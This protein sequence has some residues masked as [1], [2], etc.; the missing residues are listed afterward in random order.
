MGIISDRVIALATEVNLLESEVIEL[1]SQIDLLNF[2]VVSEGEEYQAQIA[3]LTRIIKEKEERI[4]LLEAELAALKPAPMPSPVP[5]PLPVPMPSPPAP[6]PT[7]PPII[8]PSP[9]AAP[10][11]Q[12]TLLNKTY[13]PSGPG[14]LWPLSGEY[15]WTFEVNKEITL[16]LDSL[17]D[18]L[19]SAIQNKVIIQRA[20]GDL[21]TPTPTPDSVEPPP[22]IETHIRVVIDKKIAY[23]G[24]ISIKHH[25]R[26]AKT[27]GRL[28]L[29]NTLSQAK[30]VSPFPNYDFS[31]I[32]P[33]T[34]ADLSSWQWKSWRQYH[35]TTDPWTENFGFITRSF[36]GGVPIANEAAMFPPW[37]VYLALMGSSSEVG[38]KLYNLCADTWDASGNFAI[39]YFDRATGQPY[40]PETLP[41]SIP[42]LKA[43]N[44]PALFSRSG[45][46]LPVGDIAHNFGLVNFAALVT[47]E[48]FYIE[49]L[50]SWALLGPIVKPFNE[51]SLGVYISGQWRSTAWWLRD[52]FHLYIS[53]PNGSKRSSVRK[54]LV[55]AITYL[56]DRF[57]RPTSKHYHPTGILDTS[58]FGDG[59]SRWLKYSTPGPVSLSGNHHFLAHVVNEIRQSGIA[60]FDTLTEPLLRHLVKSAE[61]TWKYSPTKYMAPWLKHVLGSDWPETMKLTFARGP[62]PYSSFSDPLTLDITAWWRANVIAA[63]ELGLPWA[64]E[65]LWWVDREIKSTGRHQSV[66][67]RIKPRE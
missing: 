17:K 40:R 9:P 60:G 57:A 29:R 11:V 3:N 14:E 62:A 37:D 20:W 19:S 65:A 54:Q 8:S 7:P 48:R 35:P 45:L 15:R 64:K 27:F 24:S 42:V 10:D 44:L 1:H 22:P 12:I 33:L 67:W 56:T 13:S 26:H 32:A 47:G 59:D 63:L 21:P 18:P 43:D 28:P 39:H 31:S 34:L 49:E 53:L 16:I 50:E 38:Q 51:R 55:D 41:E 23:D 25:T 66:N 6:K 5:D 36:T 2:R 30:F 52:I 58:P 46:K 61:G 4:G